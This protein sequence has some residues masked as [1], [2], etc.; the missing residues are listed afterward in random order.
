MVKFALAIAIA[1][2][3]SSPV[4]ASGL[5][6]TLECQSESGSSIF[7]GSPQVTVN[8]SGQNIKVLTPGGDSW[9][10]RLIVYSPLGTFRAARVSESSPAAMPLEDV[11]FSL[12]GGEVFVYTDGQTRHLFATAINAA[13]AQVTFTKFTCQSP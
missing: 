8:M 5:E 9:D 10:Y 12:I 1:A 2:V 3:M 6:L 7:K 11:V 13:S 4:L